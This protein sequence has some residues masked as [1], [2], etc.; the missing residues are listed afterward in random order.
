MEIDVDHEED[1]GGV[2]EPMSLEDQEKEI[3]RGTRRVREEEEVEEMAEEIRGRLRSS[4]VNL[5][6]WD[7]PPWH[8]SRTGALLNPKLVDKGMEN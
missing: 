5:V 6:A 4:M 7:G 3:Q 2:G 8:D 1:S